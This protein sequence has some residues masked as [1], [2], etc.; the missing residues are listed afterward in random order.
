MT[1]PPSLGGSY[2]LC[3]RATD[4][5]KSLGHLCLSLR[6][7]RLLIANLGEAR[8]QGPALPLILFMLSGWF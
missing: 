1:C 3:L 5:L 7:I 8:K 2:V 4:P 6:W